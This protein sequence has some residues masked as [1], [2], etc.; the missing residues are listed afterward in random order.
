M[1]RVSAFPYIVLILM[2]F[3]RQLFKEQFL[4]RLMILVTEFCWQFL[5]FMLFSYVT[6]LYALQTSNQVG[7]IGGGVAGFLLSIILIYAI[8]RA[9]ADTY[10]DGPYQDMVEF[11]QE[12]RFRFYRLVS[13]L[14][15]YLLVILIII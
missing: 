10:R 12:G 3:V 7:I 9:Y 11:Y 5:S 4:R 14:L 2:W 8:S 13:V 15:A 6:L 1:F